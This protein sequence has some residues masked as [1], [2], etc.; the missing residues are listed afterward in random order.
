MTP[1]QTKIIDDYVDAFRQVN[2]HSPTVTYSHGWFTMTT[3]GWMKS[4]HRKSD[5]LRLTE[6][7]KYRASQKTTATRE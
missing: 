7:L 2:G 4:K 5:M 1:E 3:R 6:A